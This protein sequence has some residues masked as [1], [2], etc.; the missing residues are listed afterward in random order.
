TAPARAA[1]VINPIY[2]SSFTCNVCG[3]DPG[4][5]VSLAGNSAAQGAINA[6]AHQ[7]GSQFSNKLTSNILFY[8]VHA[9]TDGFL[10]ASLSSQ[11]V[12]S[13]DQYTAALATD[14]AHNPGNITLNTAVANL[15]S[16][17][18]ANDPN[19]LVVVNTTDA[20][21]LHLGTGVDTAFGPGNSTPQF[22]ATGGYLGGGGTVDGVVLLNLDQPLVY[23]RPVPGFTDAA[24]PL[25]DAQ[26]SVEHEIDEIMGIGGAGSVLNAFNSDP[27]YAQD[28]YGVDGPLYGVMDLYRYQLGLP[29]FDPL[30]PSLTGCNNPAIC[31]GLPSAYFS[32]DG[33]ATSIDAFNQIFPVFGGDAGDWGLNVFQLCA[34]NQG[35]GGTGDVQDAF[36][37]NNHMADVSRGTPAYKAYQAIGYNAAPEPATW[38][39]LTL[40][41]GA[42]GAAL[43]RRRSA[44]A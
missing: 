9:G 41:F 11:T 32:V 42:L 2:A 25:Y 13:Y 33:G 20:R 23:T 3:I 43:R 39:I 18:G 21:A 19:A 7:I 8:G 40:G 27:T 30:I 44:F 37:C 10:A 17:N 4:T 28:F 31:S 16:G 29:S 5:V 12:Y 6:A 36:S 15:G 14:A 38:A 22:D 35:I 26:T 24:G 34:G 1:V